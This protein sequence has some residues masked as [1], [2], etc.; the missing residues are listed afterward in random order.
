MAFGEAVEGLPGQIL[1]RHLALELDRIA[2]VLGHGLSPRKP[3]P[4]SPILIPSP[5][6]PQGCTPGRGSMLR[7][8]GHTSAQRSCAASSAR[9]SPWAERVASSGKSAS[10]RMAA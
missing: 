2:A 3:G 10:S 9:L 6:H 1:L 5:V 4:D 7:A 8:A